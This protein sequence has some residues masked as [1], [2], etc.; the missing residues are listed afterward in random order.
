MQIAP[1]ESPTRSYSQR[2]RRPIF[3][4]TCVPMLACALLAML[5]PTLRGADTR[6]ATAPAT[7]PAA[8]T[9]VSANPDLLAAGS[10]DGPLWVARVIP[11]PENAPASSAREGLTT[12]F[13]VRGRDGTFGVLTG[14]A[15]G[16]AVSIAA[17]GNMLAVL[18]DDGNWFYQSTS[19]SVIPNRFPASVGKLI[20]LTADEKA[21]YALARGG[22]GERIR[23]GTAPASGPSTAPASSR[24]ASTSTSAPLDV[25]TLVAYRDAAWSPVVDLPRNIANSVE[26][27]S[28]CV[29]DGAIFV[30][31]RPSPETLVLWRLDGSAWTAVG[32]AAIAKDSRSARL[33]AGGVRPTVLVTPAAAG[34]P[35]RLLVFEPSLST[36]T[37]GSSA[38]AQADPMA[39]RPP[40][41]DVTLEETRNR[42]VNYRTGAFA[43]AGIFRSIVM[44]DDQLIEQGYDPS[45]FARAGTATYSQPRETTTPWVE[46][47]RWGLIIAGMLYII[48]ASVRRREQMRALDLDPKELPLAPVG[49]RLL[50]GMIDAAPLIA[51]LFMAAMRFNGDVVSLV[52]RPSVDYTQ[53]A[54]IAAWL[55]LTTAVEVLAGRS[56]GKMLCGLQ[57]V[58]IDGAAP[59]RKQLLA[60]NLLRIV[61]VGLQFIPLLL[62][63]FSPLRQRAGDAAAGTLVITTAEPEPKATDQAEE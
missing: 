36:P 47:I 51:T 33:V 17:C 20:A 55:V 30:L 42:P 35:D 19:A 50:A 25:L 59:T 4:P 3:L 29:L 15:P 49:V 26:R 16:R 56:I 40:R 14:G 13:Y 8:S 5:A 60:R 52:S 1:T 44:A 62:V 7:S 21:V 45:T 11:K 61:D 2:R 39:P 12:K 48:A 27:Q 10:E 22:G 54:G 31:N 58:A 9:P 6:P 46:W 28:L 37:T 53:I 23:A 38:A 24:P 32:R 63:P 18:M 57:V 43:Y 34:D 41:I